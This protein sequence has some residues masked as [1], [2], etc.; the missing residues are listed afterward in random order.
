MDPRAF[1]PRLFIRASRIS[2]AL[3]PA[4]F[5]AGWIYAIV[6]Y[7]FFWGLGLGWLPAGVIAAIFGGLIAWIA[8]NVMAWFE[9][10][11][12]PP[13]RFDDLSGIDSLSFGAR[14]YVATHG[15]GAL[16]AAMADHED[17]RRGGDAHEAAR[18]SAVI[19][20][21]RGWAGAA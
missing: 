19:A 1:D 11:R 3:V 14:S 4:L 8:A 7:G 2:Q 6:E 15:D 12:A 5:L 17:A 13:P 16:G 18:L 20:E 9:R 10:R 21:L